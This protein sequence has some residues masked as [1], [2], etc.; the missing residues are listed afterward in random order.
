VSGTEGV[1]DAGSAK[2]GRFAAGAVCS[3]GSVKGSRLLVGIFKI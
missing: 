2:E 3:T 1:Q